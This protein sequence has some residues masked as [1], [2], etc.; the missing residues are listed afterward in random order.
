MLSCFAAPFYANHIAQTDAFSSNINGY[1]TVNGKKAAVLATN[2]SGFGTSPLGPTWT[3]HYFLGADAQ[4]RDVAARVLYGGRASLIIGIALGRSSPAS[5]AII[6]GVLAGFFGGL[7]D[8][9]ISRSLDVIWA[10]P[11]YLLAI[12]LCTA[13]LV[14][15]DL[16]GAGGDRPGQPVDPDSDHRRR[17]HPVRGPAG[18]RRGAVGVRAGV[19]GGGGRPGRLDLEADAVPRSCQM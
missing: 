6:L 10:F 4:G 15:G 18:A 12:A 7:T 9:L 8:S 1:T 19:R 3:R 16:A 14:A 5:A 17:L 2:P 11:V 13:L